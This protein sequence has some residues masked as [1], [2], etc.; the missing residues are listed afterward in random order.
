MSN[1]AP[2]QVVEMTN[3]KG[4]FNPNPYR[5]NLTISELNVS[6]PLN[7]MEFILDR[8]TGRKINDPIFDRYVGHKMLSPELSERP[9][10]VVRVPTFVAPPAM[11]PGHVVA[12]GYRD[13]AGKWQPVMPQSRVPALPAPSA[14]PVVVASRPSIN[15]MSMEQARKLGYVGT[16]KLV[17]E[18]YGADETDGPSSNNNL[19][20]IK[21][22]MESRAPKA[23]AGALPAA[24]VEEVRPEVAPL[25]AGLTRAAEQNPEKLNLSRK[26]AEQA[27]EAQQGPDGV[28]NFRA[29]VK[30][31]KTKA[32]AAVASVVAPAPKPSHRVVAQPVAAPAPAPHRIIA[33]PIAAPAQEAQEAQPAPESPLMGGRP[34][35]MSQ[36]VMEEVSGQTQPVPPATRRQTEPPPTAEDRADGTSYRCGAC[37]RDFQ[38]K[39]YFIRHIQRAHR[40][41]IAELMPS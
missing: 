15:A 1:E 2:P 33:K 29:T 30:E 39:S 18:T 4:Y 31:I 41:R 16:P 37:G 38:Y 11:M 35:E 23:Q 12:Q 6:L 10:P 5:V 22:A 36:P 34:A 7:P 28:K 26:A 20:P 21:Y 9:V 13:K 24:L 19:P 40:D 25:V 8:T 3:V 14:A 32:K 17:A 27:V